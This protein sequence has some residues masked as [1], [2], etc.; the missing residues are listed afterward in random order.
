MSALVRRFPKYKPCSWNCIRIQRFFVNFDERLRRFLTA[1]STQIFQISVSDRF[2]IRLSSVPSTLDTIESYT[3][4]VGM[5]FVWAQAWMFVW[6]TSCL[7]VRVCVSEL[8]AEVVVYTL[9]WEMVRSAALL[10]QITQTCNYLKHP[11][12]HEAVRC[13]PPRSSEHSHTPAR[14][15]LRYTSSHV[16]SADTDTLRVR[17]L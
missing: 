17:F 10:Q 4:R 3:E 7:C 1:S 2:V 6:S 5:V 15:D 13:N 14:C 9:I 8:T 16:P 11:L 12:Q